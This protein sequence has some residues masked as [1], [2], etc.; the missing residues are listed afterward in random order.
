[1]SARLAFG[2][3]LAINFDCYLVDEVTA[4]G[5][6]RFRERCHQALIDRRDSATLVMISH[7]PHTLLMYCKRGALVHGGKVQFYDTVDEALDRHHH[8]QTQ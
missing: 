1:M 8:N 6:E 4:A 2:I 7:D 3:S 5:D